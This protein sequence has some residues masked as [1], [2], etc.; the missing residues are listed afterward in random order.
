MIHHL[1]QENLSLNQNVVER[2][3]QDISTSWN[4]LHPLQIALQ[5]WES[6]F[7]DSRNLA[8]KN[9]GES[10]SCLSK[11]SEIFGLQKLVNI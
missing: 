9:P 11:I 10:L 8:L 2:E 6:V 7:A 5:L 1:L 3:A 4:H